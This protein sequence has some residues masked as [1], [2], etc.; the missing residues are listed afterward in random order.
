VETSFESTIHWTSPSVSVVYI[1]ILCGLG[2]SAVF[3]LMIH[4][5]PLCIP[6]L[7]VSPAVNAVTTT[8]VQRVDAY[9]LFVVLAL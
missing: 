2:R 5:P 8:P 3:L 4:F 9:F 1:T 6:M 7:F